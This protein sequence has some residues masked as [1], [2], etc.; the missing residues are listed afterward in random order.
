MHRN[1]TLP[2]TRRLFSGPDALGIMVV[3][4]TIAVVVG[5]CASDDNA[6]PETGAATSQSAVARPSTTQPV[7]TEPTTAE[8]VTSEP[9]RPEPSATEP[10]G[11]VG[12]QVAAATGVTMQQF[13][14]AVDA[15]CGPYGAS[16][17]SL[18][19]NDGTIET[20]RVQVDVLR[21]T[22][23]DLAVTQIKPPDDLHSQ[24]D[25][26][27][28]MGGLAESALADAEEAIASGDV[29][30]AEAAI[31]THIG[32]LT[33][34]AA[35]FALMGATCA[36]A[37]SD[38]GA[39]ADLSVVLEGQAAQIATGLGSVWVSEFATGDVVRLDP[40]TGEVLA[41]INVGEGLLKVQRADERI[42]ART[43]DAFVRIDPATNTIDATL[44]K[45]DVGAFANRNWATD[46]AMWVC[47]GQ[48]LHRYDPTTVERVATVDIGIDCDVV[49]ATEDLV[50]AWVY[51]DA[52][53]ATREPMAAFIDPTTNELL[54][55][56]ALPVDVL[57]P[58]IFDDVV[59]F[60][61]NFNSTAVVVDRDGWTVAST[62]DLGRIAHGG[63]IATDGS[64]I[65]IP[66]KDGF[67]NDVLV[68]DATT[69]EVVDT[70]T[71][72]DV[73]GVAVEDGSLWVTHETFNVVQR[74]DLPT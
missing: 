65:F 47:D 14:T 27:V 20:A 69:Y 23:D 9:T 49:S 60:A 21:S 19:A 5:A 22:A 59:F 62:H 45:S 26:V 33:G 63:G 1:R 72:L 11:T 51:D 46:G 66:T 7:A 48:L 30:T 8:S 71:P 53:G 54:A 43:R 56:L 40:R 29:A 10:S 18:P 36:T 16:V 42:W 57:A 13:R 52:P 34:N 38:R 70:I 35:R 74:F 73:N 58:A 67:P 2:R 55:T 15:Y 12:D 3:A 6:S 50:V 32:V 68:V 44:A 37:D 41:R 28:R 39:S 25:E 31:D 64:S 24:F 61:G 17:G 4:C